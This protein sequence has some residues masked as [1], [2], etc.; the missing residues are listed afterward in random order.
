MYIHWRMKGV[1]MS[2]T[3]LSKLYK[4]TVR[5]KQRDDRPLPSAHHVQG[6]FKK[7]I[8]TDHSKA[9]LLLWIIF[10]IYVWC[11]PCFFVCSLQPCGHLLGNGSPLGSLVC[12]VSCVF[13]TFPCGVL[14]Q[15]W[16]FIVSISDLCLLTYLAE[17]NFPLDITI[18][19]TPQLF[20]D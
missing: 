18:S 9:V 12:D 14:V 15:E 20:L 8:F 17:A 3:Q 5:C 1:R 2:N 7:T 10:V 11:L 13:V 6:R 19:A 16:Y 4:I